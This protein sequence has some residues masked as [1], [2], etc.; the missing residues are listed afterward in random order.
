MNTE[1]NQV[2]EILKLRATSKAEVRRYFAQHSVVEVD[3]PLIAEHSVTDPY[4]LPLKAVNHSGKTHGYLQTSPEYAM[5][6]LLCSGS[7]DIYQFDK[8][9]RA[10]ETGIHHRS[11][12][13]MLEWYRVGWNEQQLMDE[14]F[15]LIELVCGS[16]TKTCLS[17]RQVF[18]NC[19]GIDP[20]DVTEA[21][22]ADFCRQKVG[23]LP[24]NML[25][26][27]YLTLL[28]STQIETRFDKSQVTFIYDYPAS[29]AA[30]ARIEATHYGEVGKRF[31]AFAGGLELAN[32][33]YE[34]TDAQVQLERFEEENAIRQRL[35]YPLIEID[36]ELINL[37]KKGLPDC[38]GVAMGFDRLLMLKSGATDISQ[39]LPLENLPD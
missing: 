16:M 28:F 27:N 2:K 26:D 4:M 25:F 29:Q 21:D 6:K 5:K 31:E 7:G 15:K 1:L 14:V 22:L 33:F 38:A 8:A 34:L 36:Y 11:E 18:I 17:Y 3:T 39:V 9:F 37:M 30:L 24:A 10:D 19:L 35:G 20:F 13:T 23:E 12:F 32:G